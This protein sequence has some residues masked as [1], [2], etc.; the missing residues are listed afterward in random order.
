MREPRAAL[1][2]SERLLGE[3]RERI[4][5][6]GRSERAEGE[7]GRLID[8]GDFFNFSTQTTHFS[9]MSHTPFPHI[10]ECI[11]FC[12]SDTHFS[13]MSHTPFPHISEFDSF[14]WEQRLL[15]S[16]FCVR[17]L[18]KSNSTRSR[19]ARARGGTPLATSGRRR[20]SSFESGSPTPQTSRFEISPKIQKAPGG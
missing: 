8:G 3:F 16:T 13:H 18:S 15:D 14:F 9:H 20:P 12:Y 19:R 6:S 17:T 5:L 1:A 2:V 4:E 10:S 11:S 7:G